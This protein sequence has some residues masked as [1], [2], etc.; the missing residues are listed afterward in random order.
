MILH[1]HPAIS[2]VTEKTKSIKVS[3]HDDLSVPLALST[4]R[5]T[6]SVVRAASGQ[7]VVLGGLMKDSVREEQAR[8]PLLG[9]IP[10]LGEMFRHRREISSKS[11][12]VILLRPVVIDS[13]HQWSGQLRSTADRFGSLHG[14]P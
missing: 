1:I 10:L 11:E 2:E 14:S 3:T 8:T 4:I 7:V 5:E 12:L 6:D 9:D 13:N